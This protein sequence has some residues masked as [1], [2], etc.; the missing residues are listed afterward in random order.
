MFEVN[1]EKKKKKKKKV[2]DRVTL[3]Y[4]W[5]FSMDSQVF[6]FTLESWRASNT[7]METKRIRYPL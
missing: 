4:S 2:F 5:A 7:L 3:W 1:P 6:G